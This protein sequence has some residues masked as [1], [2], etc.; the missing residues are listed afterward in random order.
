MALYCNFFVKVFNKEIDLD[1]DVLKVALT[2]NA[3]TP[4]QDTHDYFNDITNEITGTGYTAGGQ[5][6]TGVTVT[7]TGASNLI[8]VDANDVAWTGATFTARNYHLYDSTPASDATRPLIQYE[9]FG[10]DTTV[11]GATFTLQWNASGIF[12]V[13]V[14]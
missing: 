5:A 13:T 10:A 11:T 2:T 7:L 14:S 12:T 9:T 8:T 3:H 4:N 6:V 1:T